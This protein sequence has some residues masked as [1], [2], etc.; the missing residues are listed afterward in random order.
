[1]SAH[2]QMNTLLDIGWSYCNVAS[3]SHPGEKTSRYS[4][5][6]T[7]PTA[8]RTYTAIPQAGAVQEISFPDYDENV[9]VLVVS[10]RASAPHIQLL[11]IAHSAGDASTYRRGHKER[12]EF[13]GRQHEAKKPAE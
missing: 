2:V 4:H 8:T 11:L 1:M 12:F 10:L 5:P 13:S 6:K 3:T 7:T 9:R